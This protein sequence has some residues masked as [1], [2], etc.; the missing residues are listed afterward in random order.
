[1][2]NVATT[3][4]TTNHRDATRDALFRALCAALTTLAD[5]PAQPP[6]CAARTEREGGDQMQFATTLFDE[7]WELRAG[8]YGLT[9]SITPIT[10][11]QGVTGEDLC[12]QSPELSGNACLSTRRPGHFILD[13]HDVRR[14]VEQRVAA[15]L[16]SALGPLAH[17]TDEENLTSALQ[18]LRYLA[19]YGFLQGLE[20]TDLLRELAALP[21]PDP[22]AA[23]GHLWL[24]WQA[25]AER[26]PARACVHLTPL[27]ALGDALSVAIE[28]N[29]G[30]AQC[31][32]QGFRLDLLGP[33]QPAAFYALVGLGLAEHRAELLQQ[34]LAQYREPY[35]G[36]RC[37]A[38]LEARKTLASLTEE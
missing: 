28:A 11:S 1:M 31:A 12:F 7:T 20:P 4:W 16:R 37:S 29:V 34:A 17:P 36:Y 2:G 15:A 22:R 26:H 3:R 30:F 38:A 9:V 18:A 8:T 32:A 19:T 35:A 5:A 33:A 6:V 27:V 24:G 13:A 10:S 14:A 23:L 25:L 21:L